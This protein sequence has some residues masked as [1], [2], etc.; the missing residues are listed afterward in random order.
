MPL[1]GTEIR[2]IGGG[3]GGLAAAIALRQRGAAVEL[4]EQAPEFTEVG[5]GLQ[6]SPN[7]VAVLRALGLEPALAAASVRAQ[8]VV[9]RDYRR[10][11]DVL[12]FNL[13]QLAPGQHYYFAH[14]ADLIR[15]LHDE[16]VSVGVHLRP[17]QRVEQ[18]SPGARP[19][20]RLTGGEV[21]ASDLVIGADG[22][23][24]RAR[25]ALNG[26]DRPFFT[27]QVAW[28]ALI[29]GDQRPETEVWVHM[30]PG[31]HLVSYPLRDGA[32][33]NLVIVREQSDWQDEGWTH[34]DDPA[35]VQAAFADFGPQAR[36]LLE[37]LDI[38]HRWGLF[39]HPVAQVWQ[40]GGVA[41]VGDAAHPTLPFLAQGANMALED[42]WVLA[43]CLDRASDP[44]AGLRHYQAR[45]RD[46]A[47][48]VIAA[49][50]GNASKYH[51]RSAPLRGAAH[52]ALRLG[53][54]LAPGRM[55]G[56]LDWLYGHDVTAG[57]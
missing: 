31:R 57:G 11:G 14:R 47:V 49:A 37:P 43:D 21:L 28:R 10:P 19:S 42:A 8:A 18:V 12:R 46:R 26:A 41:L 34:R 6:V 7:G 2:I 22:L 44:S 32:L 23:Q 30:G 3:V 33:T 45:R 25:M 39:R 35:T 53:G 51:L 20:L 56:A 54:Q 48:R 5:A 36:A 9:L 29:P 40:Q 52:L 17:G 1:K 4:L 38:V 27:G 15:L 55:L 16:A 24:S 50:N 13:A